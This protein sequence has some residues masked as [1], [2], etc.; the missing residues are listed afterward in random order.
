MPIPVWIR[1]GERGLAKATVKTDLNSLKWN[2]VKEFNLQSQGK[3]GG[4]RYCTQRAGVHTC[5][6][7]HILQCDTSS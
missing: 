6:K 4:V 3:D 2:G 1:W 7:P 5:A